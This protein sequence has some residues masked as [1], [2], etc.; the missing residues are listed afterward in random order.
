MLAAVSSCQPHRNGG[1]LSAIDPSLECRAHGAAFPNDS[2][3]SLQNFLECLYTSLPSAVRCAVGTG[4]TLND[5]GHTERLFSAGSQHQ[6]GFAETLWF[7]K[8]IQLQGHRQLTLEGFLFVWFFCFCF[9][10]FVFL[11]FI[12]YFPQLHFQC[13]PKSPPYPP[14]PPSLPTHS[15]FFWP[16]RSPVLVHIQFA[17]P[18]GLSFQ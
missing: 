5:R 15:H 11:F 14:P 1:T 2:F 18:M 9:F 17:C 10:F 13:Y 7:F 6:A 4:E 16:W 3:A 8:A 12:T